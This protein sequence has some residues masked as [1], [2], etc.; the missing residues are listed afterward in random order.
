MPWWNDAAAVTTMK[1]ECRSSI[2]FCIPEVARRIRNGISAVARMK[3]EFRNT[4][5]KLKVSGDRASKKTAS[6]T[7]DLLGFGFLVPSCFRVFVSLCISW[8]PRFFVS[9][10]IRVFVSWFP[11]FLVSSFLSSFLPCF[12]ACFLASFLPS[13]LPS[14]LPSFLPSSP[15]LPLSLFFLML[16]KIVFDLRQCFL[17]A[18]PSH[19]FLFILAPFISK[20]FQK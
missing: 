10:C 8:F 2:A 15:C 12:L 11:R 9:S 18:S 13:L 5:L 4:I 16:G 20:V 19:S 7:L 3:H 6:A 1:H 14:L 17:D